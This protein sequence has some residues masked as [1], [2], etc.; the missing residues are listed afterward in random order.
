MTYSDV[1]YKPLIVRSQATNGTDFH[2]DLNLYEPGY[3]TVTIQLKDF[4]L[5]IS[6]VIE[7]DSGT[8]IVVHADLGQKLYDTNQQRSFLGAG[9][10]NSITLLPLAVQPIIPLSSIPNGRYRF[11]MKDM[12]GNAKTFV[13]SSNATVSP[14]IIYVF[15]L[16]Y[17]KS[18]TK[19]AQYML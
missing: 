3:D 9:C 7:V 8:E 15:Q 5:S 14:G 1:C 16:T 17:T 12:H 2:V 10:H 4:T 13:N 6:D 19:K 11:Q 18:S